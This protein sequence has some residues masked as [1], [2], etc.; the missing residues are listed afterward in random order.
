MEDQIRRTNNWIY[1]TKQTNLDRPLDRG[2]ESLR[3]QM[4]IVRR[5]RF[6]FLR[7]PA[8][9]LLGQKRGAIDNNYGKQ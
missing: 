4:S 5:Q 6:Q 3:F 8:R 7:K 9:G 1:E 2:V